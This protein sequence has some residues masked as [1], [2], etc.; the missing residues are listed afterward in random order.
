MAFPNAK[1][2]KAGETAR[3]MAENQ[4]KCI[5]V[6]DDDAWSAAVLSDSRAATTKPRADRTLAEIRPSELKV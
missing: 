3:R 6:E 1:Q 4:R 5:G 2:Q